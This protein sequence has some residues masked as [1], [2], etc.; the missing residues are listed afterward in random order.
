MRRLVALLAVTIVV[1]GLSAPPVR[2][3][4][5]A[6]GSPPALVISEKNGAWEWGLYLVGNDANVLTYEGTRAEGWA[7][8]QG[9][10]HARVTVDRSAV[11]WTWTLWI[12]GWP[13]AGP[14]VG[15]WLTGTGVGF[16]EISGD[17]FGP[18]VVN[19]RGDPCRTLGWSGPYYGIC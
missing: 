3:G 2:A 13:V 9:H 4:D 7:V 17:P 1:A 16:R 15:P 11:P 8:G 10:S 19:V 18:L 5:A 14:T 12:W 6:T